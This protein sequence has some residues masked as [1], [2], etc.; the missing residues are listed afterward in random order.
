MAKEYKD[1]R[2]VLRDGADRAGWD[3]DSMG[4][5][6]L[7]FLA[8]RHPRM[9]NAF[10][11][12]VKERVEFET[13]KFI[14]P[15]KS[16]RAAKKIIENYKKSYPILKFRVHNS[17]GLANIRD[18]FDEALDIFEEIAFSDSYARIWV[19]AFENQED[20]ENDVVAHEDVVLVADEHYY[21]GT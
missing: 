12:F 16:I 4:A 11:R 8:E 1:F 17:D 20:V 14:T 5:V 3:E 21:D 9:L 7:D 19:E 15:K 2:S 18:D 10:E 6:L 13:E